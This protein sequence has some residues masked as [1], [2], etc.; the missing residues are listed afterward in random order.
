MSKIRALV[1]AIDDEVLLKLFEVSQIALNDF[2]VSATVAEELSM[3]Q[4]EVIALG[5]M[6]THLS[7]VEDPGI[8]SETDLKRFAQEI[9]NGLSQTKR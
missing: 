3:D 5:I 4:S 9:E 7:Q 2:E 6:S 8:A 1:D